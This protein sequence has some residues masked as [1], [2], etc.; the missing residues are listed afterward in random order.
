MRTVVEH[1]RDAGADFEVLPHP[2]A[3]TALREALALGLAADEVVKTVVLDVE[4]GHALAVVTADVRIDLDLVREALGD[5]HARLASEEEVERDFP[6]FELGAIPPLPDLLDLPAVVDPSVFDHDLVTFAAGTRRESIRMA[7][8]GLFPG[9]AVT[10]A[11]I[12]RRLADR[13]R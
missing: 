9:S 10:V 1:L 11:P 2:V 8:S 3:S 7:S 13:H 4:D 5:R 12:G 6:D